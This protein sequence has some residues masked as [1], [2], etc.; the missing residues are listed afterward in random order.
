[1][2]LLADSEGPDQTAH[3]PTL[4][5]AITVCISPKGTFSLGGA[6]MMIVKSNQQE[7]DILGATYMY[8]L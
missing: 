3:L 6:H 7:W 1:M 5:W 8:L 4:I 2:I